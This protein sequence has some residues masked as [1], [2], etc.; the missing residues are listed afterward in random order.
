MITQLLKAGLAAVDP[1]I[2]IKRTCKVEN[3]ILIIGRRRYRLNKYKR[4][5]LVGAGK[6]AGS[7]TETV[8]KL[9]GNKLDEGIVVVKDLPTRRFKNIE[10]H[11]AGHPT[12][13]IRSQQAAIKVQKFVSSLT[14]QDLLIALISGG[15]S[16]LL[17]APV[18]GLT[19]KD[20]HST[21]ELLLNSG[22]TIQEMNVVRK[23]LSTIKGGQFA[24]STPATIISLILSDV[25]GDDLATIGSGLTAPDTSTFLQARNIL[26]KYS[27]WSHLPSPVRHH[28]KK[29]ITGVILETPKPE[30][31]RFKHV[32]HV[33]IGNNQLAVQ[34]IKK[35]AS[36]LGLHSVVQPTFL[37]GEAKKVGN[38]IAT[39][40]RDMTRT[41][42]TIRRPVL[43]IWGGEP[44]VTVRGKKGK[45]GRAQECALSVAIG[46]AG[47]AN[48]IMAGFGTDGSDGPTNVAGAVVDGKTILRANTKNLKAKIFLKSHDSY[49]FFK[50]VGGHI[51][52][53]PS[54]TNVNDIYLVIAL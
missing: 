25:L 15:A 45:G 48:I 31:P 29:G 6:A 26:K 18:S 27:L 3:Q 50:K 11:K 35:K 39:L 38:N 30:N 13:D 28:I 4:I 17:T 14:K 8:Q 22:A 49:T 42:K 23:H 54:G 46:I 41:L 53:G 1:T 20:K 12:P 40:A 36:Q 2:G 24:S 34:H 32:H 44:T 37:Q 10:V 19:L 9:L 47:L 21:T 7:M 33:I 16:S 52:T 43:L 51:T 5:V